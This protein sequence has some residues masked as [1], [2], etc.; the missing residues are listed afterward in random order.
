MPVDV[1]DASPEEKLDLLLD[2]KA[3]NTRPPLPLTAILSI[4]AHVLI[5]GLALIAPSLPGPV[6]YEPE[7]EVVDVRK[8]TPLVLP[9]EL[10]TQH[11]VNKREVSKEIDL[12]GLVAQPTVKPSPAAAPAPKKFIAPPP[13]GP[14]KKQVT[15]DTSKIEPAPVIATQTPPPVGNSQQ[16]QIAINLPP[17]VEKPKLAFE[18]PGEQQ[19]GKPGGLLQPGRNSVDDAGKRAMR[20]GGATSV[21]ESDLQI[22]ANPSLGNPSRGSSALEL[23][24]D[25]MGVDFRPYLI[26]VLAAVRRNWFLVL[27]EG[28]RMGQRGRTVVQFSISKDG[29]VPKLVIHMPSGTQDLD[30]AAVAGISAS[31]PFPPLPLEYKGAELRLQLV[32]SYN[33]PR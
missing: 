15:I 3:D 18:N 1:R 23:L 6:Y 2:W 11:A 8:A 30:R 4:A 16:Q 32:F 20:T 24:S 13:S 21:N 27:P 19:T 10:L 7:R 28:A 17:P 5:V 9:P 22:G 12:A 33:M 29:R 26:R 14:D 25:P 31:N